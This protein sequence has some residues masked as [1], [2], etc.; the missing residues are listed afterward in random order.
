[1]FW[2]RSGRWES[3]E[4]GFLESDVN[5]DFP[6]VEKKKQDDYCWRNKTRPFIDHTLYVA[7]IYV[8]EKNKR[9]LP[10]CMQMLYCFVF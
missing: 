1:M 4:G 2:R 3:A 6:I 8:D 5:T 7:V 9:D 10:K